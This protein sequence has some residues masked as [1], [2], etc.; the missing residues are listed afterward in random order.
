MN[1]E[2][3]DQIRKGVNDK[4]NLSVNK[5][6]NQPCPE[7]SL[8][9]PSFHPPDC[10]PYDDECQPSPS[11]LDCQMSLSTT[12]VGESG[13]ILWGAVKAP[14]VVAGHRR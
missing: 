3:L 6:N 7:K 5:T 8:D 12:P 1:L 13:V 9:L 4:I 11:I 2:L 14:A 10:L